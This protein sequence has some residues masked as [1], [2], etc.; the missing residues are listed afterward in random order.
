MTTNCLECTAEIKIPSDAIDGEIVT[1]SECGTAFELEIS[2]G[3]VG[4]KPA[5]S[6]G[7]DWGE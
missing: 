6:V 7:E 3:A 1:C 5:E 4:L 2:P